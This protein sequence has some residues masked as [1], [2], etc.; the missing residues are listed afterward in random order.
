MGP[1]AYHQPVLLH[2]VLE[3]L[4]AEQN[5]MYVDGTLGGGGHAEAILSK[6]GTHGHLLGIDQDDDAL[7]AARARLS[8]FGKRVTL[9]KNN[10]S[11]LRTV[12]SDNRIESVNGIL[13]D[14]GVSS[15]QLD[16]STKGFSFRGEG[17]LD[18]RMDRSQSVSAYEVVN[19]YEAEQLAE[20]FWKYG[21]ERN[22]RRIARTVVRARN[23]AKVESTRELAAVVE[24]A[25]GGKFLTRTLARIFQAIRIEVNAELD[26]LQRGLEESIASLKPGGRLVVISYHSLEDRMVKDMFRNRSANSERSA[27]PLIPD[28]K[29]TPIVRQ[30]MR[31]PVEATEK[32]I[33]QNPRA[34]SAKL[35]AVE[36]L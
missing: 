18:M 11:E 24:Q 27:H 3:H 35:R 14:L 9:V 10:F 7:T 1:N 12:L 32:E 28:T 31:K 5:G 33:R 23:N 22:S 21:E 36:K 17:R 19:G 26:H 13:L 15:F 2:E 34:R 30:L 16:E 4:I 6:L 20:I 25:V 29:R 8:S